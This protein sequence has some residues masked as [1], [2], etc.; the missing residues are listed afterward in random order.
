MLGL[1]S[2]IA[3][4][5]AASLV[6]AST[7]PIAAQPAGEPPPAPPP[8][9]PQDDE[10]PWAKGVSAEEQ[11][12]ANALFKEGNAL[13]R[14]SFF[15][16]AVEKYREAVSHWDHPAIHYNLAIALINLDQPIEV[17]T[18]LEKAM[19]YGTAALDQEK[20]ELGE[21]YKKLI[22]QQ[23]AWVTVS[24]TEDGAQVAIDGKQVF[25]CPGEQETML[26]AGEHTVTAAKPGFETAAV[27]R[28]FAGGSRE[29]VALK[30]YRPEELTA[31][32]RRFPAWLP[33]A[34]TGA[35]VVIAGI[36]GLV[37]SSAISDYGAFDD[38]ARACEEET[39]MACAVTPE[40]QDLR[41][42]GDSKQNVA[43]VM[44]V[45]G[46]LALATGVTLVLLNRPRPY[47]IDVESAGPTGVTLVPVVSPEGAGISAAFRF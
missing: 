16:K 35:G 8:P 39:N 36:G 46:G 47:R 28:V 12:T 2:W 43:G 4:L 15:V 37:H 10:K 24:C 3:A 30:L 21:R 38:W 23:L 13:L 1:R 27:T 40:A 17:Y 41:D 26:R 11:K 6:L 34:V 33:W 19:R 42:G 29:T 9:S 45:V 25:A 7:A 32:E 22:E 18:S 14:D 20:I 31:Y 5:V 44:Y